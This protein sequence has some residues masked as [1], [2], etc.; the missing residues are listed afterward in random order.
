MSEATI[1]ELHIAN[2][3]KVQ[4]ANNPPAGP[5]RNTIDFAAIVAAHNPLTLR[6][7]TILRTTMINEADNKGQRQQIG[8]AFVPVLERL[9]RVE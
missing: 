1:R 9:R 4:A 6:E 7:A 2:A 8:D 3:A 5:N